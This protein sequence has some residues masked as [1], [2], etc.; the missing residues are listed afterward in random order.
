[1]ILKSFSNI[2]SCYSNSK[3]NSRRN[4]I[5]N[6]DDR[7]GSSTQVTKNNISMP[8]GYRLSR[9]GGFVIIII[10]IILLANKMIWKC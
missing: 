7:T 8:Y 6:S 9:F 10:D 5:E 3:W 4:N 2:I 1:L